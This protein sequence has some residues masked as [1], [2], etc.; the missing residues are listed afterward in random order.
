MNTQHYFTATK[1]ALLAAILAMALLAGSFFFFEPQVGQAVVGTPFTIKQTIS[2]EISFLVE[3]NNVVATGTINGMTG[4]TANGTT[5][6]VV[7]TNKPNGYHMTIAFT[8]NGTN[9]A[10]KGDMSGGDDVIMDYPATSN[11]PTFN[12]ST[13]SSAAVFAYTVGASDTTDIDQ[14]FR[15][16]GIVCNDPAVFTPGKC[17]MEPMTS[18]FQIIN[19]GT[20]ATTGATTTITFRIHVPNNPTPGVPAGTYTATATLTALN[21]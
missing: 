3:A 14:S 10:M 16:S 11:E 4:G 19:R 21:N 20:A 13:A 12:F 17:W 6:T 8:N 7:K 9:N 18:G 5:T 1:Q 15:D 2:D